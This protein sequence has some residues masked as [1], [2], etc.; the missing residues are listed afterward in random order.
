MTRDYGM[1][2]DSLK[3]QMDALQ[4]MM[5]SMMEVNNQV[6]NERVGHVEKMKH[7]HPNEHINACLDEMENIVGKSGQT[8]SI[9]YFGLFAS[10]GRQS[11][12]VKNCINTDDLLNLIANNVAE[13]VLIY[14]TIIV[15]LLLISG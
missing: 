1:E 6:K 5:A 8:G 11:T 12:W 9:T 7:M 2:I 4:K 10:S 15:R 3:E 14:E 13:K